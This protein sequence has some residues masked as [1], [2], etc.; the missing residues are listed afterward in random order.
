MQT[1]ESVFGNVTLQRLPIPP[2]GKKENLRAWDAADELILTHINEQALLSNLANPVLIFNDAFGA[3]TVA[4]NQYPTHSS[5]DSY[6]SQLSIANNYKLNNLEPTYHFISST[7]SLKQEYDLVLIKIPKTMALLEH[8]L[9]QLKPCISE[10]TTIVASGMAKY[11]HTSTLKIFEKVIGTTVTSRATKKSRLIFA[12]NDQKKVVTSPFPKT[13]SDKPLNISLS[14]H[15]NVFSKD[16]LDIGARFMIEHLKKCPKSDH[17]I[18]LGC[19][20]GVLGIMI[21]RL[22]AQAQ[23]SFV[24]ESYMAISSAKENYNTNIDTK[25]DITN[26][27]TVDPT[28]AEFYVSDC[29]KDSR[30]GAINDNVEL[31][32]CNPPFHQAHS[33]GD[34]IAWKMFVQS[35]DHLNNKGELW[36]I[37]NRHLAYHIKL[38]RLFGNC[39]TIAANKKFVILSAKKSLPK[40]S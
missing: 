3:L 36:V 23:I 16:H 5:S 30:D 40:N 17:I 8:Q 9:C 4:L 29:L 38:K 14:N 20:N 18:D 24:D 10:N 33:V 39:R 34:Q 28:D 7:E 25:P 37:G 26:K 32:L 2:K 12:K 27:E 35:H 6:L 13:F 31:I 11:I 19:G 15:A 22:Q 21:K 1:L